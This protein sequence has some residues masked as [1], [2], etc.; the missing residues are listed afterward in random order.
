MTTLTLDEIREFATKHAVSPQEKRAQ[1]VSMITGMLSKK[2]TL[3]KDKVESLLNQLE[4][5]DAGE[6][7]VEK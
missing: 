3:T 6:P 7:V 5:H 4:G 2:S 1:R